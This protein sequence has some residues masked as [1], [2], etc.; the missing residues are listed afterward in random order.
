MLGLLAPKLLLAADDDLLPP[1]KWPV[2][3][4]QVVADILQRMPEA[5]RQRIR[6]TKQADLILYHH[7]W[8]TGI[9]NY[10]GLWRG[11]KKLIVSACGTPCHP[12]NASMIIIE[13]VWTALQK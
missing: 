7:G 11:N 1:E 12:D 9:R 3:V 13:A 8:G 4:A 5:D 2:T 10:Y 6:T